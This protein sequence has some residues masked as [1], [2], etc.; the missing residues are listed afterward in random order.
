MSTFGQGGSE[1]GS[2]PGGEEASRG[3]GR[4]SVSSVQLTTSSKGVVQPTVKVYHE[5]PA[6]ASSTA[7]H[8]FDK[9]LAKYG[10]PDA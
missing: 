9:L 8:V 7:Q 3:E 4:E 2:P 1:A 5:N 10:Q 6:I